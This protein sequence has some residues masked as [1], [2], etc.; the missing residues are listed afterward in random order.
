MWT[1]SLAAAALLIVLSSC[2]GEDKPLR[3]AREDD[4]P[5]LVLQQDDVDT[6]SGQ[7]GK[8]CDR[9][10]PDAEYPLSGA[11]KSYSVEYDLTGSQAPRLSCLL[12]EVGVYR[13][14]DAALSELKGFDA[15]FFEGERVAVKGTDL[16]A[17]KI[18][19]PDLGGYSS[20]FV[21]ECPSC[22]ELT[23]RT[24]TVQIQQGNVRSLIL[25]SAG[26]DEAAVEQAIGYAE[27]QEER[28]RRVLQESQ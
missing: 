26:R 11:A 12:S 4:L 15:L 25:V 10:G 2:G 20:G 1:T 18:K 23:S 17:Q 6:S 7:I 16:T 3:D 22:S 21:I 28:I 8:S 9:S 24:Y 13:S 19:V 14:K 27:K 5:Q